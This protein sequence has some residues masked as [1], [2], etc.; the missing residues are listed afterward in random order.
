MS[1]N[2]GVRLNELEPSLSMEMVERLDG[3]A[4]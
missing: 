3:V 2:L 4:L 1:A